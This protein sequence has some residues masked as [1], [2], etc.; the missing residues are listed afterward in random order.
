MSKQRSGKAEGWSEE[1][2]SDAIE[3]SRIMNGNVRLMLVLM[4]MIELLH[5]RAGSDQTIVLG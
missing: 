5:A 3:K 2:W 1:L 4:L